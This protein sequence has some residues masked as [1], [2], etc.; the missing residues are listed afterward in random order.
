MNPANPFPESAPDFSDPLGLLRACHQ[1]ML[2]NCERLLKLADHLQ[3]QGADDEALKA[4]AAIY[5][6]FTTSARHHHADEEQDLFPRLARESLKLADLVHRLK[7]EHGELDA[8]WQEL[9]P[10]LLRPSHI[11]DPLGFRDLG[12]R[13]AEAYQ[14]HI[15]I[16]NN[17]L[18]EMARHI[19]SSAE[20][21]KLGARM[22]ERRGV[23]IG[24]L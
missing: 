13:F 11:A 23:Q 2:D 8:L 6:Y 24:Y 12:Q 4:A 9:E 15:R 3:S 1:R 17:D 18:L 22:A 19:L 10:L 5:R 7:Q 16:E 21:K 14:R 20:L